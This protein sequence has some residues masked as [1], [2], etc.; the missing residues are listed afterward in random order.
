[1]NA[2]RGHP[3]VILGDLEARLRR[4]GVG[5][6]YGATAGGYGVLSVAPGLNVW[7]DDRDLW[8]ILGGQRVTWPAADTGGAA[9]KLAKLASA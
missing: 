5:G 4:R 9:G 7:T 8:W 2:P 3:G 6:I 1:M